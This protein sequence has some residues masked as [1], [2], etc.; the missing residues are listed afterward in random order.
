MDM[1]KQ[2][3]QKP[4]KWVVLR[5]IIMAMN[6]P[7]KKFRKVAKNAQTKVQ[8][9]TEMNRPALTSPVELKIAPKFLRPTQSKSTTWF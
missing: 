6:I 8:I 4:L 7:K 1:E 3:R 2:A 5:L 9:S